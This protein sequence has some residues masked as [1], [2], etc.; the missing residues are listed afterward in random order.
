MGATFSY[1]VTPSLSRV[2]GV[3]G[4]I[5]L[6][7]ASPTEYMQSLYDH[8][9][10]VV[11]LGYKPRNVFVFGPARNREILSNPEVSAI[12]NTQRNTHANWHWG[13]VF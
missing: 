13:W 9:G 2:G 5:L 8:F 4:N 12:F 6:F 7:W 11:P 3:S 10:D 1:R